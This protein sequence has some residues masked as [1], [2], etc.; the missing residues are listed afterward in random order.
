MIITSITNDPRIV[1]QLKA[2]GV[3]VLPTDT[4]Y[5]LVARAG[6]RQ[7]VERLYALKHRERKPGTLI[8]ASQSQ[9]VAL[10]LDA[11]MINKLAHLWPNPL[12]IVVPAIPELDYLD[13]GLGDIA[14]RIPADQNICNLLQET[15]PLLTTSANLPGEEPSLNLEQ[16]QGYFGDAVDFYV[17]GGERRGSASTV[18]RY[19]NGHFETLR[20]GTITVDESGQIV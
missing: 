7:A 20:Q 5:G 3:G 8:A 1:A 6:D 12:S 19:R 13:Q 16:A 10:G 18:M 11:G 2:G 17:D 4:I 9:L 15:G 14:A